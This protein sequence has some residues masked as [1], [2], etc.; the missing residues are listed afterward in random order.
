MTIDIELGYGRATEHTCKHVHA[1]RAR[2]DDAIALVLDYARV[3]P[4]TALGRWLGY[5]GMTEGDFPAVADSF[6]DPRVWWV[7]ADFGPSTAFLGP[8]DGL[9]GALPSAQE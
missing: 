8:L 5:V 6:R 1:G 7:G 9:G 4:T 3:R 2:L